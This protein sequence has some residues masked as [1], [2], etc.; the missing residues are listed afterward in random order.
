MP[1]INFFHH[2]PSHLDVMVQ[3]QVQANVQLIDKNISS[4]H[5][6]Y[7]FM[8]WYSMNYNTN[9][10]QIGDAMVSKL[11]SSVIDR[12]FESWSGQTNDYKIG[13]CCFSSKHAILMNKRAKTGW[14]GIRI[15]CTSGATCLTISSCSTRRIKLSMLV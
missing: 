8:C 10:N 12:E 7:M 1:F 9:E 13:I 14:L 6:M 11:T 3:V 2:S 5:N 15:M 4:W